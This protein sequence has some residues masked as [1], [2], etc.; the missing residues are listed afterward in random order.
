MAW[1]EKPIEKRYFTVGEAAQ[2]IGVPGSTVRY[3]LNR[4]DLD[5]D[6][7]RSNNRKS[8]MGSYRKLTA[9][10][11]TELNEIK[12][13]VQVEGLHIWA[14]KKKLAGDVSQSAEAAAM[15]RVG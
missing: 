8:P 10:D 4:F 5:G 9:A 11:L 2:I 6:V 3:W 15:L 13:L 14:A 1:K 7:K 12:R